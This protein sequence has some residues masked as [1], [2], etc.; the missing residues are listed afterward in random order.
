MAENIILQN[1]MRWKP[2]SEIPVGRPKTL[3]EDGV[4]Q[5]IKS[6]NI[7]N[8]KKVAQN[9][10]SWKKVVEQARTLYRLQ[11][12]IRRILRI[13]IYGFS[14]YRLFLW[15]GLLLQIVVL[16]YYFLSGIHWVRLPVVHFVVYCLFKYSNCNFRTASHCGQT[17]HEYYATETNRNPYCL[18][19]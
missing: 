2:M 1:I 15:S 13:V 8:W 3:W 7:S 16:V 11:R 19:S 4:L 6:I 9:R 17:L 14:P 10:D 5:D 12:F 18:I